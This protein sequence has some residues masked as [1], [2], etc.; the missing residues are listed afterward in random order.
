MPHHAKSRSRTFGIAIAVV[1]LSTIG[2]TAA[3]WQSSSK[4][5]ARA[6]PT[7]GSIYQANIVVGF[8]TGAKFDPA[9]RTQIE[10][11]EIANAG[12]LDLRQPLEF[13]KYILK[14][15]RVYEVKDELSTGGPSA[16]S[17]GS[18]RLVWVVAKV[19]G[20]RE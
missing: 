5:P 15:T 14:V 3:I 6:I 16:I 9:D 13:E 18:R 19:I 1:A 7:V 11:S 17:P 12:R 4:P 20:K 2:A 10:F 8:G